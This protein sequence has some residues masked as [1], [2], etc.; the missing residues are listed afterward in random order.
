ML[1]LRANSDDYSREKQ[2]KKV[3][4]NAMGYWFHGTPKRWNLML[5]RS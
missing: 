2:K 1:M 3:R 5:D 4:W